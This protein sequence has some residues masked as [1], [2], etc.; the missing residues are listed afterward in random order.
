[1]LVAAELEAREDARGL[2]REEGDHV[3]GV[4]PERPERGAR[5]ERRLEQAMARVDAREP[6]RVERPVAREEVELVPGE[7]EESVGEDAPPVRIPTD[8]DTT[9]RDRGHGEERVDRG[10][11]DRADELAHAP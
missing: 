7:G 2:E 11:D 4:D 8:V 10:G 1:M 5:D 3:E 6:A 9:G